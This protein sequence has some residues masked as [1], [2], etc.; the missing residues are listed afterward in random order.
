MMSAASAIRLMFSHHRRQSL[1]A[2]AAIAG[3]D[4]RGTI[5]RN[6]LLYTGNLSVL[7]NWSNG[8]N[9]AI[10][11]IHGTTVQVVDVESTYTSR[12][13]RPGH[14]GGD[15]T[16]RHYQTVNFLPADDIPFPSVSLVRRGGTQWAAELLGFKGMEFYTGQLAASAQDQQTLTEFHSRY[17]V[18]Q[19]A[20]LKSSLGPQAAD[21][22]AA[23]FQ[24]LGQ[25]I[26]LPL[27]RRLIEDG[28]WNLEL[29]PSHVAIWKSRKL[30]KPHD[31]LRLRCSCRS[32]S[33]SPK[34]TRGSF[35][36]GR[37]SAWASWR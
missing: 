32:F 33:C 14:H 8:T 16:S 29:C 4:F 5:D 23:L 19:G 22:E 12:Q 7:D 24:R 10:G 30:V 11:K 25:V 36:S 20:A 31:F 1:E 34:S 26:G 27:L 28:P 15:S 35:S 17:M 21:D 37:S 2:A 3:L 18:T 6:D 9:S 13:T